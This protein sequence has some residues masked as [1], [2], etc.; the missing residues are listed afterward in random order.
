[1]HTSIY[2]RFERSEIFQRKTKRWIRWKISSINGGD[3]QP[4][5]GKKIRGRIMPVTEQFRELHSEHDSRRVHVATR[6][7]VARIRIE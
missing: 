5:R 1:M 4:T 3:A 7:R 2:K 6:V